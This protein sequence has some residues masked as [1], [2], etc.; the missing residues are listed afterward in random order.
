MENEH[1]LIVNSFMLSHQSVDG[2]NYK[3]SVMYNC[4]DKQFIN[5]ETVHLCTLMLLCLSNSKVVVLDIR[6]LKI[7]EILLSNSSS[8]RVLVV[9]NQRSL[10]NIEIMD[11]PIRF[12]NTLE[13]PN[14]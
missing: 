8:L 2:D 10:K 12:L 4:F 7:L 11:S 9:S 13:I 5:P 6:P 14:L 1:V 3:T